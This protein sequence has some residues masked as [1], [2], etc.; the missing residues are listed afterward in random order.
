VPSQLVFVIG[1]IAARVIAV[2]MRGLCAMSCRLLTSVPW[3]AKPRGLCRARSAS[4]TSASL[5]KCKRTQREYTVRVFEG[6]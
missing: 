5:E 3:S 6:K 4:C 1:L 2:S